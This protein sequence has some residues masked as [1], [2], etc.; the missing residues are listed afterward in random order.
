MEFDLKFEVDEMTG[1]L[2]NAVTALRIMVE[3][4]D[5]DML[6]AKKDNL[7]PFPEWVL[8][9]CCGLFVVVRELD[10]ITEDLKAAVTKEYRSGK[11]E[12]T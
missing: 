10:R 2:D 11:G 4:L 1:Y 8:D 7:R 6:M 12:C 9:Q 3:G 5:H